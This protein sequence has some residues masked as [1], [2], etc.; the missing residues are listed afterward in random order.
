LLSR[1]RMKSSRLFVLDMTVTLPRV[2]Y[3]AGEVRRWCDG[4]ARA[5]AAAGHRG[6]HRVAL[7]P[8]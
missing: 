5:R 7:A 1:L 8:D 2:M 4:K 3:R 6:L